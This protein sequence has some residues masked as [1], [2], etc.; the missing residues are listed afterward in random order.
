MKGCY[1]WRRSAVETFTDRRL[2]A[3]VGRGALVGAARGNEDQ[4]L[5]VP[6]AS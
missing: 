1:V 2:E 3:R 5:W 6:L 4:R